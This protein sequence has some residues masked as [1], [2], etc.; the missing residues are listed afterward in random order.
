MPKYL[1]SMH[2]GWFVCFFSI[3]GSHQKLQIYIF[4]KKKVMFL[5]TAPCSYAPC[6][7]SLLA[8]FLDSDPTRGDLRE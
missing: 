5:S 1:H 8:K 6:D 4:C 2:F 3:P 7:L